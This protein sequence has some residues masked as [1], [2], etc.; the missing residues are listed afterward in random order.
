MELSGSVEWLG[1]TA[2]EGEWEDWG[3]ETLTRTRLRA[4]TAPRWGISLF[5]E[6]GSGRWG[7]PYLPPPVAEPPVDS[8]DA[9]TDPEDPVDTEE[10]APPVLPGPRF[11]DSQGTRLGMSFG[12]RG[13]HFSGAKLKVTTDSLFLLGLPTDRDGISV[14]DTDYPSS[15]LPGGTR[16]GYEVTGRIPLYPKG[17]ALSG[18]YQW[19]DQP[20]VPW[21]TPEDSLTSPEPLPQEEQPWR[22]LPRRNYQAGLNFHDT[23]FPTGNLEVWFDLGV[24]GRDAMAV[25]FL[26]TVKTG[27]EE[28]QIPLSVPFYQSWFVRLQ[29]R[30]VT[31]RVFFEWENFTTRQ[32]NQDFPGR[33]LIPSRSL[34]GVRW[35]MWN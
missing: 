17:F 21:T 32:R 1:G 13:F 11:T 31:V 30:V 2:V 10:P 12:W 35:T 8:T 16:E 9:A 25:P 7:L 15:T 29:I 19:W 34:Y 28:S 18:S 20:E 23:F 24:A 3:S 22:Y 33:V 5:A 26:E 6:K 27:G 4:W 14:D